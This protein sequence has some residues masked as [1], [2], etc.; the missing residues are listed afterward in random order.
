MAFMDRIS[1]FGQTFAQKSGEFY[2][3]GKISV[4]I[5]KKE[6]DIKTAKQKIGEIIY[7]MYEVGTEFDEEITELCLKIDKLAAEIEDLRLEKDSIGVDTSDIE[8]E[9]AEDIAEAAAEEAAD[10]AEE[11]AEEISDEISSITE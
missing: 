3:S 8:V 1:E 4:N 10:A 5:K 6:K 11:I 9:D 2:E 7:S